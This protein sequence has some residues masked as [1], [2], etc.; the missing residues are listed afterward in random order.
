M[1]RQDE[2]TGFLCL[3]CGLDV[4][5]LSNGSYRNHCPRC[6]YSRHVDRRPGDRASSCRSL[7]QPVGLTYKAKKGWQI[8]HRCERCRTLSVNKVA[9]DTVQPDDYR[10]LAAVTAPALLAGVVLLYQAE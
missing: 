4:L 6:L 10:A 7:M 9:T 5:A 3:Q 8:V 2:N 1:S